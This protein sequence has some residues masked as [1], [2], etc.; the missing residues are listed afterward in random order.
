MNLQLFIYARCRNVTHELEITEF[1]AFYEIQRG[2]FLLKK[3]S[4][5]VTLLYNISQHVPQIQYFE[6]NWQ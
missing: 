3:T 2:Y 1:H 6:Y 5:D 4:F